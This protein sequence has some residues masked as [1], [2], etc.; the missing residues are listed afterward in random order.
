MDILGNLPG[1]TAS[2][3]PLF[4]PRSG[5]YGFLAKAALHRTRRKISSGRPTQA[6]DFGPDPR[7]MVARQDRTSSHMFLALQSWSWK[8][9]SLRQHLTRPRSNGRQTVGTASSLS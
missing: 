8:M 5:K 4:P 1:H 3:Q 6:P 7:D 2:E 9:P